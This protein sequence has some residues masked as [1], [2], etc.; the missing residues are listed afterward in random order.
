MLPASTDNEVVLNFEPTREFPRNSEGAFGNLKDGRILFAYS[1]FYGGDRDHSPSRIAAIESS[2]GGRTWSKPRPLVENVGAQNIMSVSFI[3]MRDGSLAMFYLH[4][5]TLEDLTPRKVVS[6]DEGRTWSAPEPT[7]EAPGY[8]VVNNDRIVRLKSG[9]LVA[10]AAYHR[11]RNKSELD[12]NGIAM[13]FLSNDDGKTW[14]ESNTKWM[15]PQHCWSGLQEPGVVELAD[16]SIFSWARTTLGCQY[17]MRSV[18]DCV[19]FSPPE[20]SELMSPCGPASIKRL[21][22]SDALLCLFNDHSG[23][24]P[25][26]AESDWRTPLVAGISRDGGRTWPKRTRLEDDPQGGFHYTAIHYV[27]E[28]VLLA[29]CAGD[30]DIGWLNRLR[31]RRVRL[32]LLTD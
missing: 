7:F 12:L 28:H 29:Y 14:R 5:N 20:P 16:G 1:Q 8:F 21:P 11:A 27:G 23:R 26:R 24:F 6:L 18:D 2:D 13:W 32:S 25:R 17:V 3:R 19:H 31:I 4:R 9:R 15:A 30:K 10:P 22:E